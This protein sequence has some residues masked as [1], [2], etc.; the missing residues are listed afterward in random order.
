MRLLV[1]SGPP[2]RIEFEVVRLRKGSGK[3]QEENSERE[4][5]LLLLA[6]Y[7]RMEGYDHPGRRRPLRK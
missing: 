3:T 6:G 7:N 2:D 4:A 1:E 5:L